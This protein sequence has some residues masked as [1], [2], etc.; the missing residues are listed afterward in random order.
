MAVVWI[1]GAFD[2][3]S[4][5]TCGP[6]EGQWGCFSRGQALGPALGAHGHFPQSQIVG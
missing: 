3:K 4:H 1:I 6:E 2:L 5:P